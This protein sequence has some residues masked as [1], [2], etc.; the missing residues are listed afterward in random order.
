MHLCAF[1]HPD[2]RPNF[3]A[4][5]TEPAAGHQAVGDQ[6]AQVSRV[7]QPTY[8]AAYRIS[9]YIVRSE[10]WP[11]VV[12]AGHGCR[13][14]NPIIERPMWIEGPRDIPVLCAMKLPQV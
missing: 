3:A 9:S 1:L 11:N 5:R 6:A 14:D 2:A 4:S 12:A 10:E 13:L 7:F 8:V